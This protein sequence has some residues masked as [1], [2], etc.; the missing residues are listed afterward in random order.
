VK[1]ATR[2]A[3]QVDSALHVETRTL[4]PDSSGTKP[5]D[6][7]VRAMQL[8]LVLPVSMATEARGKE[9]DLSRDS[10]STCSMFL[11]VLVYRI[12]LAWGCQCQGAMLFLEVL[13]YRQKKF[14]R[15]ISNFEFEVENRSIK[16]QTSAEKL[17]LS[18]IFRDVR[19]TFRQF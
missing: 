7:T 18:R 16:L 8:L 9:T 10:M 3:F 17:D 11:K 13:V 14:E 12:G 19:D 5:W 6:V 2:K 15:P 4:V 1:H